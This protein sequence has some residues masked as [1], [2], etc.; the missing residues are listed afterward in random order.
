MNAE[1]ERLQREFVDTVTSI[2]SRSVHDRLERVL[3]TFPLPKKLGTEPHTVVIARS[4]GGDSYVGKLQISKHAVPLPRANP[5]GYW[6]STNTGKPLT[7][8]VVIKRAPTAK[9]RA[10]MKMQGKYLAMLRTLSPRDR[11]RAREVAKLHGAAVAVRRFG[12]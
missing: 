9:R 6:V 2:V 1:I 3:T 4:P 5:P 8:E 12:G 10:S 7:S 11:V